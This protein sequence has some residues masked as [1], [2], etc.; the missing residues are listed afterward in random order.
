MLCMLHPRDV[1]SLYFWLSDIPI[2]LAVLIAD[3]GQ[4]GLLL[5]YKQREAALWLS[6]SMPQMWTSSRL[7]SEWYVTISLTH[8]GTRLSVPLSNN[9]GIAAKFGV[10]MIYFMLY[11]ALQQPVHSAALIAK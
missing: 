1:W 7:L 6:L 9:T 3:M 11:H 4:S 8:T 10:D 2:S 5:A